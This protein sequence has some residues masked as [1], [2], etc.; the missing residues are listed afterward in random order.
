VQARDYS[1]QAALHAVLGGAV[2][3]GGLVAWLK[4]R[5]QARWAWLGPALATA[6]LAVGVWPLRWTQGLWSRSD[7]E[8]PVMQQLTSP[9]WDEAI[10]WLA[11]QPLG[12]EAR[13]GVLTEWDAGN[14][15]STFTPWAAMSSRYPHPTKVG[16]YYQTPAQALATPTALGAAT[17]G[18]SAR[19]V[20]VEPRQATD[21]LS[22]HK[23]VLG[24][25]LDDDAQLAV[26]GRW[27]LPVY[28]ATYEDLLVVRLLTPERAPPARFRLVWQSRELAYVD[29][30]MDKA[31]GAWRRR[32][33]L[34]TTEAQQRRWAWEAAQGAIETP[35]RFSY[36]GRFVPAVLIYEMLPP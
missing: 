16:F 17:L 9:A 20:I 36:A 12:T 8:R 24:L 28:G 6:I 4:R 13:R 31:S 7:W 34:V 10:A 21:N 19:Y 27:Q 3:M 5:G 32:A 30:V 23:N 25:A 29:Y 1:Y 26:H 33:R 2:L 35:E 18:E 22:L 11:A 15:V 14:R